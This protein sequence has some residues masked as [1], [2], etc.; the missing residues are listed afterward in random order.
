[1][2]S[3]LGTGVVEE[4]PDMMGETRLDCGRVNLGLEEGFVDG[5]KKDL[6]NQKLVHGVA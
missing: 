1:M 2:I 3:W 5:L 4:E 6:V